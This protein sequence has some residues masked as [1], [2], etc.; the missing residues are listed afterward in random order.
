MHGWVGGVWRDLFRGPDP[1][2]C[3]S[4]T[5]GLPKLT[6]LYLD[7]NDIGEAGTCARDEWGCRSDWVGWASS[8][9]LA[10]LR[11]PNV[12]RG[13]NQGARWTPVVRMPVDA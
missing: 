12:G 11:D 4:M 1:L 13:V 5:V 10:G 9:V 6:D 8:A 7:R 3:P 2:L